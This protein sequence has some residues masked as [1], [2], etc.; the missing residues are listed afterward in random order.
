MPHKPFVYD[1]FFIA[2]QMSPCG[3]WEDEIQWYVGLDNPTEKPET[4]LLVYF[5]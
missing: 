3:A 4:K 1:E 2:L 5:I